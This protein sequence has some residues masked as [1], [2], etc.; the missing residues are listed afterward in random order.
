MFW[1]HIVHLQKEQVQ[2]SDRVCI[3]GRRSQA[4]IPTAQPKFPHMLLKHTKKLRACLHGGRVL[5]LTG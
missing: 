1:K 5:M 2:K 4:Q 3:L